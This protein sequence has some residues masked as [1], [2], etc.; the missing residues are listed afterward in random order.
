MFRKIISKSCISR[1][2]ASFA[3]EHKVE[4]LAEQFKRLNKNPKLFHSINEMEKLAKDMKENPSKY[5]E[6]FI[7]NSNTGKD[8]VDYETEN[9]RN[10]VYG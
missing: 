10:S 6:I 7:P 8:K 2:F 5:K 3:H 9:R 4:P 1:L